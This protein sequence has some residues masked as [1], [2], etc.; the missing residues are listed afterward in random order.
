MY[1]K[2]LVLALSELVDLDKVEVLPVERF[3]YEG[4]IQRKCDMEKML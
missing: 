3:F 2:P 1:R 4:K